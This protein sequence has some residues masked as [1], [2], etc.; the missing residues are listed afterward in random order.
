MDP[1]EGTGTG[2]NVPE[3]RIGYE[4]LENSTSVDDV[5]A[6]L[7]SGDDGVYQELDEEFRAVLQDVVLAIDDGIYPELSQIGSSG[8]YFVKD[9]DQVGDGDRWVMATGG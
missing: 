9:R 4:E 3:S 7:P 5:N 2:A 1:G 6:V 8:C